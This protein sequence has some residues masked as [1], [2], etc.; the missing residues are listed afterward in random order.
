GQVF[1]AAHVAQLAGGA[2]QDRVHHFLVPLLLAQHVLPQII[3]L[4]ARRLALPATAVVLVAL[5]HAVAA[6]RAGPGVPGHIVG[7][8]A[9]ALTLDAL[10]DRRLGGIAQA[11][12]P[13]LKRSRHAHESR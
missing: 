4:A 10:A 6:L 3:P 2:G 9:P 11:P 1:G 7:D 8:A 13:R 12:D 5:V